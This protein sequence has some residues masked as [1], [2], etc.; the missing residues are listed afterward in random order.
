MVGKHEDERF[1]YF[2]VG[3]RDEYQSIL[4]NGMIV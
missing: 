3:C 2:A 1:H 4:D